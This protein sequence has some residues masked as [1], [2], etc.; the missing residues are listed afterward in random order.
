MV[1]V[2]LETKQSNNSTGM[3]RNFNIANENDKDIC[4]KTMIALSI[5]HTSE[6]RI[7]GEGMT[8]EGTISEFINAY[9]PYVRT[10]TNISNNDYY[11]NWILRLIKNKLN[12]LTEDT[13]YKF[14]ATNNQ[15]GGM[16]KE[17]VK[18]QK[19]GKRVV[20]YG[21]RGGKYYMKGGKKVY[22]K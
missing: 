15:I 1:N 7:N 16:K 19:G 4:A 11:Y 8:W 18:L 10:D 12:T 20:R 14:Y 9:L 3:V 6:F 21:K 2:T 13:T 5:T 17:Y 22:I